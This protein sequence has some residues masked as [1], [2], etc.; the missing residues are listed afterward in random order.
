[1]PAL[2][3]APSGHKPKAV[4]AAVVKEEGLVPAQNPKA[5]ACQVVLLCVSPPAVDPTLPSTPWPETWGLEAKQVH[6]SP[7]ACCCAPWGS[8]GH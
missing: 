3:V 8:V 7:P 1:M 2:D 5:A 4:R 6:Q